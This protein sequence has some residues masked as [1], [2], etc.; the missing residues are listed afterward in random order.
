MATKTFEFTTEDV[1]YLTHGDLKLQLTI[2]DWQP[3]S[4][5]ATP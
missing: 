1:Q 3:A 4:P 2:D 5:T